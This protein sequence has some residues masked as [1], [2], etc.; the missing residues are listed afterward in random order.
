MPGSTTLLPSRIHKSS[1]QIYCCIE[2][3]LLRDSNLWTVCRKF[4]L[5]LENLQLK[6]SPHSDGG[7]FCTTAGITS[8]RGTRSDR[9][10]ASFP[11]TGDI[12]KKSTVPEIIDLVF[13]KTSP[14]RAFSMTEYKRIGVVFTKTRVYKFRHRYLALILVLLIHVV[15][16]RY[17]LIRSQ[18]C[19][20]SLRM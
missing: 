1:K 10:R 18:C 17:P 9:R 8:G 14:K 6:F 19:S 7:A 5:D 3:N 15:P 16:V 20:A 13:L 12:K 2:L 4:W 11:Y